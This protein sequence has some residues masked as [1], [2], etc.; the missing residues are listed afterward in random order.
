MK[1][2]SPRTA[3][4]GVPS[5]PNTVAG[6]PK[7]ARKYSDAVSSSINFSGRSGT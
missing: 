6:M 2:S 1:S 4:T 7:N 5:L 3:F